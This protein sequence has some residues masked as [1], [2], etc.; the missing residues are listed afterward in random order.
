MA[1]WRPPSAP[2]RIACHNP[3][4]P[5]QEVTIDEIDTVNVLIVDDQPPFRAVARTVVGLASGF[6]VTA[7]AENGEEAV[8]LALTERPDLVLMD[9]NMPGIDGI[10]ATREITAERPETV[11]VLLSTYDAD[12]LP[13]DALSCGA[14]RY[15][16]KEDFSPSLLAE[17]WAEVG[18]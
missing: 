14:A 7:E 17:V 11:V 8:A 5:C 15:V 1:V 9:I 2:D 12:S 16:H 4:V 18:R 13:D 6:E 10:E 3:E